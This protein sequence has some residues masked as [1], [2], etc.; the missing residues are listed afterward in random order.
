MDTCDTCGQAMCGACG[1]CGC[2]GNACSCEA[3]AEAEETIKEEM[4]E[5]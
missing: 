1:G 4:P 3:P 5:E 2:E